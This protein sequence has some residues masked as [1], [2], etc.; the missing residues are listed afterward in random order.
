VWATDIV[1]IL[2]QFGFTTPVV[3][4]E[5][6]GCVPVVV[7]A[8]WY[9]ER[10]GR[11]LLV[12]PNAAP[13]DGDDAAAWSLRDCP[14]DW[15]ALRARLTRGVLEVPADDPSLVARVEAALAAPLP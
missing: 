4:G 7:V 11:V 9:P 2:S 8:A 14:P 1:G 13:P 5:G 3:V 12:D 6:V 15:R 10:L